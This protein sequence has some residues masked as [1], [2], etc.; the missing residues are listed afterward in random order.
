MGYALTTLFA[1]LAAAAGWHYMFYSKSAA[2][3]S[4]IEAAG[5]NRWRARLRRLNGFAIFLLGIFF[6]AG[7]HAVKLDP[8]SRA[9][10][11][12]WSAVFGLLVLIVL[13]ALTDV[14]LTL[15]L[16]RQRERPTGGVNIEP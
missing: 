2:R 4:A 13:L 16:K 1:L 10:F 6:F 15:K 5:P 12:V 8:P 11:L 7:F 14:G 3:L 9:F